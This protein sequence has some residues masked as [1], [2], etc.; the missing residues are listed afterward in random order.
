MCIMVSIRG[1]LLFIGNLSE[2]KNTAYRNYTQAFI[3]LPPGKFIYLFNMKLVQEYTRGF[4]MDSK[5]FS[6]QNSYLPRSV[7]HTE[8]LFFGN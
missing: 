6:G 4:E 3:V 7:I 5:Y 2:S 1:R 8:L